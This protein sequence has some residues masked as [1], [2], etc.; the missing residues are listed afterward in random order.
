MAKTKNE[1]IDLKEMLESPEG[2]ADSLGKFETLFEKYK[3]LILGVVGGIVLAVAGVVGY[4]YY[5]TTQNTEAQNQMFN[6]VYYFEADSLNKALKGDGNNLGF[7]TIA[8]DY[9]ATKAGKLAS[10]YAGVVLMKQGKYDDAI[11][12]L[13]KYNG[14][15]LIIQARAY[16]LL[17]DAN[18]EKANY[19]EAAKY[20]EKAAKHNENKYFTPMYLM[21]LALV[22]EELKKYAEASKTYDKIITKYPDFAD[23]NDAKKYKAKVEEMKG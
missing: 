16:C 4:N 15:D 17:G 12:Y 5:T 22:Q 13:E 2:L 10:F 3:N 18:S 11:A 8:S 14:G 23:I 20:Y 7:E 21:K 6:A 9:S 1:E 19:E